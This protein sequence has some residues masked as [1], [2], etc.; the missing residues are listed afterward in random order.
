MANTFSRFPVVGGDLNVGGNYNE[1]QLHGVLGTLSGKLYNDG[2]ALK[3]P[4]CRIGIDNGTYKGISHID[5]ITSV[6]L[7]GCSNSTCPVSMNFF[8]SLA[9][10]P[11]ALTAPPLLLSESEK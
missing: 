8:A 10:T 9:G 4:K 6:S 11:F 2:G 7:A 3:V 5:T 1:A